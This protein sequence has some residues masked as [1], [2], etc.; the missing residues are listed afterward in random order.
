MKHLTLIRHAKSS[1]DD[2]SL[3]D[4]ERPLNARGQRDA[5][6]MGAHLKAAGLPPVDR[7]VSSP[8]RRARMTAEAI[9]AALEMES[10][11]VVWEQT[12]YAASFQTLLQ[13]VQNL[14]EADGHVILI[15]HNPGFE[16]LARRLYPDFEGDGVK[17]P[18]CGVAHFALE[19]GTWAA[20][21]DGSAASCRFSYPKMLMA[22]G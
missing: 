12:I 22:N 13:L 3:S 6:R 18:T 21:S 9:A 11:A 7:I 4:F 5:P 17:F 1:W 15:G 8:A 2:T 10:A 19:A 20:V 16:Q 14:N